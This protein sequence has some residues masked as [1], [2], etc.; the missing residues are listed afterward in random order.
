MKNNL[1]LELYK[2]IEEDNLADW[3]GGNYY[4]MTKDEL[5]TVLN[6]VLYHLYQRNVTLNPDSLIELLKETGEFEE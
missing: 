6:E 4:R 1:S 2:A 3:I 5:K